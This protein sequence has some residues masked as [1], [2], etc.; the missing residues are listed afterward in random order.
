MNKLQKITSRTYESGDAGV[1]ETSGSPGVSPPPVLPG[2]TL[3]QRPSNSTNLVCYWRLSTDYAP[4]GGYL[5]VCDRRVVTT[6]SQPPTYVAPT[7]PPPRPPSTILLDYNLGWNATARSIAFCK[8]DLEARFKAPVGLVGVVVGLND[9]D[10]DA[11]YLD[12]DHGFYVR[13]STAQVVERGAFVGNVRAHVLTNIYRITRSN[14][15]VRYYINNTLIHTSELPSIGDAHL[16]AAL[17]SGGDYVFDPALDAK[18]GVYATAEP[19]APFYA[20]SAYVRALPFECRAGMASV[21]SAQA[22]SFNAGASDRGYGAVAE[23]AAPFSSTAEGGLILPSYGIVDAAAVSF[24]GSALGF[25]GSIGGVDGGSDAFDGYGADRP[26]GF[27]R[28]R[29]RPFDTQAHAYEG[30]RTASLFSAVENTDDWSVRASVFAVVSSTGQVLATFLV[31][32]EFNASIISEVQAQDTLAAAMDAVALLMSVAQANTLTPLDERRAEGWVVQ[33][34]N[35][36]ST[37][38]EGYAFNSF[39]KIGG[40]YYGCREDGVYLLEGDD[41]TGAPI[42]AMVSFGK[43]DFGTTALKRVSNAYIGAS[44]TGKLYLRTIVDG[45]EYTYV[46]RDSDE[47]M[48][49]QRIDLGKGLRANWFEFEM[50][51]ADGDNFELASVEFVALPTN[52]RI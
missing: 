16:K 5:Y 48:Q 1:V 52:R 10:T 38:Y 22:E 20:N 33:A 8:G 26:Y 42:S 6:Y 37:R 31:S 49:I 40:R 28:S 9:A 14:G 44:S 35:A 46:A 11:T 2:T 25:T 47:S 50:Y 17:Y 13:S 34:E 45:A 12:I 32:T 36:G 41:D 30:P 43:T 24:S 3:G 18:S 7:P 15:L 29:S 21:V 19:F 23:R 51:N 39:A 4:I 27:V